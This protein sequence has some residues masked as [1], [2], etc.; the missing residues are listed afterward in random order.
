MQDGLPGLIESWRG[1]LGGSVFAGLVV[2]IATFVFVLWA[3]WMLFPLVMYYQIR[4]LREQIS[5]LHGDLIELNLRVKEGLE[6]KPP[7]R[8]SRAD[9]AFGR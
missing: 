3:M 8:E 4:G 2:V 7:V 9:D 5:Q 1:V 6:P